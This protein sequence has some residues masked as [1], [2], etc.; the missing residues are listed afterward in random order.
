[1]DSIA[2]TGLLPAPTKI[3]T[4]KARSVGRRADGRFDASVVGI[5][6]RHLSPGKDEASSSFQLA[7]GWMPRIDDDIVIRDKV[8]AP[9]TEAKSDSALNWPSRPRRKTGTVNLMR[10][11]NSIV[12]LALSL[13]VAN[14]S[15]AHDIW[16]LPE[17][18]ILS[19]G[20]TLVVHQLAGSEL[21]VEVAVEFLWRM[22]PRF[23]LLTPDG[24]VDLLGELPDMKTQPVLKPVLKRRLNFE[25]PALL[26]MD[27][28]F[29]YTEFSSEKFLE[30]LEHE[31]FKMGKFRDHVGDRP[32]QT[33]RYARTLKCLLQVGDV[34]KGDLHKRVMGQKLEILLLQRRP[35]ALS[36]GR[37]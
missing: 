17:R 2:K 1:M 14:L 29:I 16:L 5:S 24:S 6:L 31:E 30:Y 15:E 34:T 37:L 4:K 23:E 10:A 27:H 9:A 12:A 22:T 7:P 25:G 19:K 20:D 26:T 11:K 36:S 21:E 8:G 28:A 35:P 3:A 18:F 13:L 32:R 33:E